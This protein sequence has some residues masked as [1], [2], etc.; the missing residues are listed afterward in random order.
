MV[1]LS[2]SLCAVLVMLSV[3]AVALAKEKEKN[4][5]ADSKGVD[6]GSFGVFVKG[7]RAG[8]ETFS[9]T[10]NANGSVIHSVFKAEGDAGQAVQES[11]LQLTAN[12]EI[13]RYEWKEQNPGKAQ[14]V[15]VPNDQFVT[16]RWSAG[17]QDKDHEQPYLLPTSTSILDDY[18]FVHREVLAWKYLA[19][20]CS[21]EKDGLRCPK[22]Q[23]GTLNPSQHSS[24]P[25]S[26]EYLGH[27]KVKIHDVERDLNKL[28]LKSDALGNWVIWLDDQFK[29]LLIS[30]PAEST[31]VVRD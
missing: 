16:Q 12:G 2:R 31:E 23:F 13:R 27:D 28:E 11:E 4:K 30:I 9:V 7:R 19:G 20:A 17:P 15:V 22:A 25:A 10:Q 26:M 14:S 3:S 1:K 24:A 6:S 21:R 18:F 5:E 29:V 8:T